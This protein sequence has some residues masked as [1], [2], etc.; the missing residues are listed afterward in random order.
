MLSNLIK[1]WQLYFILAS[2]NPQ[3]LQKFAEN[4]AFAFYPAAQKIYPQYPW[5]PLP[6][7]SEFAKD[8]LEQETGQNIKDLFT[9]IKPE[10]LNYTFI[11]TDFVGITP[12]ARQ[13]I[14]RI[15]N[16]NIFADLDKELGFLY[17]IKGKSL[18]SAYRLFIEDAIT[19]I[20][21]NEDL[22]FAGATLEEAKDGRHTDWQK[23]GRSILVYED[24]GV[25][26]EGRP[27]VLSPKNFEEISVPFL[28]GNKIEAIIN[29]DSPGKRF[30]KKKPEEKSRLFPPP[31]RE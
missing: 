31:R 25:V 30:G 3:K 27:R 19:L 7:S 6:L 13:E 22:R 20:E 8:V 11:N 26:F 2:K 5:T 17:Y 10:P 9:S 14:I 16:P 12:D 23:T 21:S 18:F 15:N 28:N 4:K 24:T 29:S 1:S